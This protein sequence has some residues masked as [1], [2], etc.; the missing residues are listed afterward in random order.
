[1]DASR[2]RCNRGLASRTATRCRPSRQAPTP[3]ITTTERYDDQKLENLQVAVT[4]L[5]RG[6]PFSADAASWT[7]A[8]EPGSRADT[9][10]ATQS[11]AAPGRTSLRQGCGG[12]PELPR[13]RMPGMREPRGVR[14]G[15]RPIS[16][17]RSGV[18]ADPA[19]EP[20]V[21]PTTSADAQ[22][23]GDNLSSFFQELG[24]TPGSRPR[25]RVGAPL[26]K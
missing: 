15:H 2:K 20:T 23:A 10:T 16:G 5:E 25:T 13:R 4:K 21:A 18:G 8:P 6:L 19:T 14:A 22:R 12:S 3:C 11:R 24:Q 9:D 1:M 26:R 17:G 7:P